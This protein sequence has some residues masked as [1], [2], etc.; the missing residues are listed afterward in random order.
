LPLP[1]CARPGRRHLTLSLRGDAVSKS[2]K[3][4][5]AR[6][7]ARPPAEALPRDERI[8]KYERHLHV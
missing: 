2:T 3:S 6:T 4:H 7:P 8:A 5:H 1:D